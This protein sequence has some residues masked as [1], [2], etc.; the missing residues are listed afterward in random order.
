MI[1]MGG[2]VQILLDF[3]QAGWTPA[4]SVLN[5][6]MENIPKMFTSSVASVVCL[7]RLARAGVLSGLSKLVGS[8]L[9]AS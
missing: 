1:M 6:H 2:S 5:A 8:P 3:R 4:E 7:A 9:H